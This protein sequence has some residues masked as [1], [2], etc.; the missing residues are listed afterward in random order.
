MSFGMT[1]AMVECRLTDLHRHANGSRTMRAAAGRTRP[2]DGLALSLHLRNRIGLTL[3]EMGLHLLV[4]A[5]ES[6]RPFPP[7]RP[8]FRPTSA[9]RGR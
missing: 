4:Q 5:R 2:D 9:V 3:V 8:R 7:Q 1:Q 6:T